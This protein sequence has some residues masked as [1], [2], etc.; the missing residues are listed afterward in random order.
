MRIFITSA[1]LFI[2]AFFSR[3]KSNSNSRAAAM[4]HGGIDFA[5]VAAA[6]FGAADC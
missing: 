4:S 3:S 1:C 6:E 5:V 2:S